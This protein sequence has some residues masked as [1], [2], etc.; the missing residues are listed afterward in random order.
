MARTLYRV[1]PLPL[2]VRPVNVHAV[3]FSGETEH[4]RKPIFQGPTLI[5]HTGEGEN[6]LKLSCWCW[7][8]MFGGPDKLDA[9]DAARRK[10]LPMFVSRNGGRTPLGWFAVDGFERGHS[11][12]SPDGLGQ[13]IDIEI[14][15]VETEAPS[16]ANS[17]MQVMDLF[18]AFGLT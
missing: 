6:T 7:P 11:K 10:G 8:R 1:G 4:A 9:F 14:A 13:V 5:E 15:A 2:Q 18:A 17:I 3:Q 12:L 16:S